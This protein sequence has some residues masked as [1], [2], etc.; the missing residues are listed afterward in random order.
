MFYASKEEMDFVDCP[1][2]GKDLTGG[3][4][5]W[6]NPCSTSI[7]TFEVFRNEYWP[8]FPRSLTKGLGALRC[9]I[10]FA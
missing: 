6:D 2:N 10:Y 8:H 9:T 1:S 4:A 7:V 5:G 3:L